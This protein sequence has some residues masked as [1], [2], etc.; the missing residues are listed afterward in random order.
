MKDIENS[1]IEIE[2]LGNRVNALL[3]NKSYLRLLTIKY[4]EVMDKEVLGNYLY[5]TEII[6]YMIE[7]LINKTEETDDVDLDNMIRLM[8]I[9]NDSHIY[10]KELYKTL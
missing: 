8:N 2:E 7:D 6:I 4:N 1:K 10:L 9:I 3:E 5:E